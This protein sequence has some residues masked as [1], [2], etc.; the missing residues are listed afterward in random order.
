MGMKQKIART[1]NNA[2]V[3][4]DQVDLEGRAIL[5]VLEMQEI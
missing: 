4:D 2:R 3:N 5:L 1:A